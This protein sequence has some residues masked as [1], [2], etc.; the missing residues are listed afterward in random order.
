MPSSEAGRPC[1]RNSHCQPARPFAPS[2]Y[3]MMPPH[4]GPAMTLATVVAAM[5]MA[6]I[7]PRRA[8]GYQYVRYRMMPGK[9]PA[10]NTP[11]RKRST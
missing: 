10:S 2:M 3:F 9:K 11:S 4:S 7:W 6:I 5:K 8:D 1:T